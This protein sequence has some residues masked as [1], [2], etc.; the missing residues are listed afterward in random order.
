MLYEYCG[1]LRAF[2]LRCDSVT[3]TCIAYYWIGIG[4]SYSIWEF[5]LLDYFFQQVV[6][7]P[8]TTT[9]V[10]HAGPKPPN[11]IALSLVNLLC[12]CWPLGIVGLIYSLKVCKTLWSSLHGQQCCDFLTLWVVSL[13]CEHSKITI[14][15]NY[16]PFPLWH[17]PY[18]WL[19]LFGGL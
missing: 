9:A 3:Y 4:I 12:C 13:L 5:D 18:K 14:S 11:Y 16:K 2:D 19:T 6:T 1:I 15:H 10:L 17:H 8:Q 7:A